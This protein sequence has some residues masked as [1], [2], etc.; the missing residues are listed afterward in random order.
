MLTDNSD[1]YSEWPSTNIKRMSGYEHK[2]TIINRAVM[3][4]KKRDTEQLQAAI[5]VVL[6]SLASHPSRDVNLYSLFKRF[7][8]NDQGTVTRS[9]MKLALDSIG[10]H[11]NIESLDIINR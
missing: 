8:T 2:P 11:L 3:T 5:G 6:Q 4:R 9:D 7:D 10:V 1:K